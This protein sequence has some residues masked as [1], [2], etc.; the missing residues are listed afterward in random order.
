MGSCGK[1]P[2]LLSSKA[3]PLSFT[4]SGCNPSEFRTNLLKAI[5]RGLPENL[6]LAALTTNPAKICGIEKFAGTLGR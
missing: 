1:Y 6:A 5:D 2:F 3:K 4:T